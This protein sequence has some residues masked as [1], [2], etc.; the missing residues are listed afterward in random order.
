M[1]DP[2]AYNLKWKSGS[3]LLLSN[4]WTRLGKFGW[5]GLAYKS[6]TLE[7]PNGLMLSSRFHVF[8]VK[9]VCELIKN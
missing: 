1:P 7:A 3:I 9:I 8:S 4:G 6:K 5:V 2:E